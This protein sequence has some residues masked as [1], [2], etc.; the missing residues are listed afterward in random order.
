MDILYYLGVTDE[1]TTLKA[2]GIIRDENE[3][4]LVG[5]FLN[6]MCSNNNPNHNA[7]TIVARIHQDIEDKELFYICE[8]AID[9][10]EHHIEDLTPKIAYFL[11]NGDIHESATAMGG[12]VLGYNG[13]TISSDDAF[14]NINVGD[15][16]ELALWNKITDKVQRPDF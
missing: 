13:N 8:V 5:H 1:V 4:Y 2:N 9:L 16:R 14:P 15:N 12:H 6:S 11:G 7:E 3:V 10:D